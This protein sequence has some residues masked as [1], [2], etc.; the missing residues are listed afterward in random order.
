MTKIAKI[1]T[2]FMTETLPF[3]AAHTYITHIREYPL[4]HVGPGYAM[5]ARRRV[6]ICNV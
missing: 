3:E 2:L 5:H 1:D 6:L 4:P